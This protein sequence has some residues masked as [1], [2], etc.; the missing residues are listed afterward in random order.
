MEKTLEIELKE[1]REEIAVSIESY[2][3]NFNDEATQEGRDSVNEFLKILAD[4]IRQ[5]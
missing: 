4:Y 2:P 5:G 3:V 1:Q